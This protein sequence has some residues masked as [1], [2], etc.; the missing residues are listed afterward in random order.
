VAVAHGGPFAHSFAVA[1]FVVGALFFLLAAVGVGGMSP[2][3]GVVNTAGRI[4]GLRADTRVSPGTATVSSTAILF[5]TA[6]VLLALG[7]VLKG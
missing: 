2:S 6:F 3:T 7:F 4:P 5:L 1:C